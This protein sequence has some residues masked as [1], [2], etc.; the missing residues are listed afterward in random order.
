MGFWAQTSSSE[1]RSFSAE[2][3]EEEGPLSL[4]LLLLQLLLLLLLQRRG[5]VRASGDREI[6]TCMFFG[7]RDV[8]GALL[9]RKLDAAAAGQDTADEVDAAR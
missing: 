8:A 7:G 5:G 3:G 1:R 4:S 2:E 9:A 6:V